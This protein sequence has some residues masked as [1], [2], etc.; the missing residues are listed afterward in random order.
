MSTS[1]IF[2]GA[3]GQARVLYELIEGT[4]FTLVAVVDQRDIPSPFPDLPLLIGET[5]LD[6]WLEQNPAAEKP[7]GAVAIGGDR[8]Q[9]R[10][11]VRL[12][13]ERRGIALPVLIHRSAFVARNVVMG[14]ASQI[15]AGASVCA[16]ASIGRSVIIN[17][18]GTVDHDC[19]LED[20]V[21]VG[22]G[23]VIAG[24]VQVRE[25]AFIGAGA[26]ILPRIEIGRDAVVGAGA[27]VTRNVLPGTVVVGNP[28]RT[29]EP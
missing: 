24:E 3:T 7:A 1:I 15:L 29:L 26:T 28:A 6:R 5:G 23:A 12:T 25:R 18:A 20:G 11:A 16:G 2:W 9:D 17:T 27:V 19:I 22:P 21:H 14:C 4:D 13:L 8:G 10:I